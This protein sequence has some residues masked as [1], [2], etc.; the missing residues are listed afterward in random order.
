MLA[1]TETKLATAAPA[2]KARL[3]QRAAVLREWLT[4]RQS[5]ISS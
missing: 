3:Q 5:S 1:E 2:E 4:P